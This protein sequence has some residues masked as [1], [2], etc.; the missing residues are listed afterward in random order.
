MVEVVTKWSTLEEAKV[1]ELRE[2]HPP[3]VQAMTCQPRPETAQAKSEAPNCS[4]K[5]S[6]VS[7]NVSE[8][9]LVDQNDRPKST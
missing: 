1:G 9:V 4:T 8:I 6:L 7:E 3:Y 5:G 2:E